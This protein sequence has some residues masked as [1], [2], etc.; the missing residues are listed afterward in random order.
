MRKHPRHCQIRANQVLSL[1]LCASHAMA[2]AL[3]PGSTLLKTILDA[4]WGASKNLIACGI[5]TAAPSYLTTSTPLRP[6]PM[7]VFHQWISSTTYCSKLPF[8]VKRLCILVS[9][10]L[11]PFVAAFSLRRTYQGL[12]LNFTEL[13]YGRIKM[14]TAPCQAW[15]PHL[16]DDAD[17][18]LGV[19]TRNNSNLKPSGCPSRKTILHVAYLPNYYQD[20]WNRV[21][22]M[23]TLHRR[24]GFQRQIDGTEMAGWGIAAVSPDNFVRILCGPVTCDPRHPAFLGATSCSN[25][26]A[27]L[28]GFAETFR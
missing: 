10:L 21:S 1:A 2:C 12:G 17:D 25:N 18:V 15:A 3:L 13:M 7:S 23:E 4:A 16:P 27:E 8:A 28:T 6:A 14:M 11:E 24:R 19:S 5:P 20:D 22:P 26:T 9:G